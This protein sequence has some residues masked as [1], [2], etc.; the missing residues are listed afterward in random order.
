MLFESAA[1]GGT[2]PS[3]SR[4]MCWGAAPRR[5]QTRDASSS[6]LDDLNAALRLGRPPATWTKPFRRSRASSA[7]FRPAKPRV[8]INSA[9]PPSRQKEAFP[10]HLID[11]EVPFPITA[12]EPS[13]PITA[14]EPSPFYDDEDSF[15][16]RPADNDPQ[17]HDPEADGFAALSGGEPC[18]FKIQ[19]TP[20]DGSPLQLK[21]LGARAAKLVFPS[22]R[23][24]SRVESF[25]RRFMATFVSDDDEEDSLDT[26]LGHEFLS[27]FAPL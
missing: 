20:N 9:R 26:N 18:P 19:V 25:H 3:T 12:F 5:P 21:D 8:K 17:V 23:R 6:G 15:A 4:E 24:R 2:A 13:F 10:Q 14:F 11:D 27:L 16:R 1:R 22:E 7:G